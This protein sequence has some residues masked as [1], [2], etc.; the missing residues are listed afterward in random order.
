[1]LLLVKHDRRR[2]GAAGIPP[3]RGLRLNFLTR[4]FL[5]VELFSLCLFGVAIV[6]E[7]GG[8]Q[9]PV[10]QF[11]YCLTGR[12]TQKACFQAFDEVALSNNSVDLCELGAN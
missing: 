9:G 11:S 1:M 4:R 8:P 2:L 10:K 7:S 5:A 3:L 12:T 6:C